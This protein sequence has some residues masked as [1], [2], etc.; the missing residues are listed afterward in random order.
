M[1]DPA[2][3]ALPSTRVGMLKVFMFVFHTGSDQ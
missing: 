1:Q 2:D 3:P